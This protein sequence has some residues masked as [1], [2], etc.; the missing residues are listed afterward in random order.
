[1][2]K[3]IFFVIAA[4]ALTALLMA[5]CSSRTGSLT[6]PGATDDRMPP[7]F[8]GYILH[9]GNPVSGHRVSVTCSCGSQYGPW[10]SNYTGSDGYWN[11]AISND[12]MTQHDG[13]N[14][15]A[16]DIDYG[17]VPLPSAYFTFNAPRVWVNINE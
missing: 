12:E 8:H 1:M 3:A 17:S 16:E 5:G 11:I 2:K 15:V 9:N 13:H 14:M 6:G 4:V 10:I 7:G